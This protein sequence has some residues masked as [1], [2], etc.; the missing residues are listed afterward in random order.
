MK[1]WKIKD[2][3]IKNQIVIAPMAGVSNI[4]FRSILAQYQ[5]GL[6]YS[7]MISDR[8]IVYRNAKTIAMT[9]VNLNEHPIALQL[10]GEDIKTMVLAAQYLDTET[11]CDIIDIN[12]G[13]P[14]PK[15]IK[16]SGGASLLKRPSYA[17]Q[18]A[19]A[20]VEAVNKPVT[21]KLRVGWDNQTI[22]VLEMAL[23]LQ[24]AG[25]SAISI[26]GRTRSAMYSGSVDY[27]L[28]KQVKELVHIPVMANGDITTL[29]EAKHVLDYTKADA[30]MIGR[31]ILGKPWFI[32]E[33]I[34]GLDGLPYNEPDSASRFDI[35][36]KHALNLIETMGEK[37][38][39]QQ[40][41]SHFTWYLKGLP[42]S[43]HIKNSI[44]QMTTYEQFD[45]IIKEYQAELDTMVTYE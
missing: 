20:V 12:M 16:G 32:Q 17:F 2:L 25:I 45:R 40:M 1:Q 8:A 26:H 6:I 43:H 34:D 27:E 21:V 11:T 36:R 4:A 5:P 7:E 33:L 19:K 9:Q 3:I 13:C 35:A 29:A 14:V 10:F 38:A 31:G 30:I 44:T 15:V 39:M 22:N 42:R 18:L 23:G 41:R 24:E 37:H 28:I